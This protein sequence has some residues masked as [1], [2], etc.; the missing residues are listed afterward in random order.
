S[1]NEYIGVERTWREAADAAGTLRDYTQM[2]VSTSAETGSRWGDYAGLE[3]DPV[4]PGTF[5]SHHEFR[6]TS[7]RT[8]IGRFTPG[9]NNADLTLTLSL[10]LTSNT[11]ASATVEGTDPFTI[12]GLCNGSGPGSSTVPGL[13]DLDIDNAKLI[14][15]RTAN[16]AGT[17]NINRFLPSRLAGR[18]VWLQVIDANGKVSNVETTTIL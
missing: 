10:P 14:L 11:T 13:G 7:W 9:D 3:E 4:N 6:T 1:S 16:A 8:W 12:I 17:S 5:W 15:Q 18:T 2:Q